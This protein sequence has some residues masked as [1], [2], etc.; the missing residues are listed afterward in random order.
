M[1]MKVEKFRRDSIAG[2]GKGDAFRLPSAEIAA[3]NDLILSN[4]YLPPNLPI[5]THGVVAYF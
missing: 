4:V 5:F 3:N 2:P 1:T